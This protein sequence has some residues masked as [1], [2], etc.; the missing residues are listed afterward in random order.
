MGKLGPRGDIAP[1]T[2]VLHKLERMPSALPSISSQRTP[3]PKL[4]NCRD[5]GHKR[6]VFTMESMEGHEGCLACAQAIFSLD[7]NWMEVSSS[8]ADAASNGPFTA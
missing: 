4:C 1:S 2:R 7:I 5:W 3:S 8:Y 6:V